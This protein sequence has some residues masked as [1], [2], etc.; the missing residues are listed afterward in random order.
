MHFGIFKKYS[1]LFSTISFLADALIVMVSGYL[2]YYFRF[3]TFIEIPALYHGAIVV[4]VIIAYLCFYQFDLY[5]PL[6]G[7]QIDMLFKRLF[8]AWAF[9]LFVF[10]VL[11]LFTKT[12]ES[13]SRIWLAEWF[14]IGFL[15]SVIF[16]ILA[17]LVMRS[18]RKKGYNH[19][20][21]YIIGAG[22]LG[23]HIAKTIH[24]AMWA[25]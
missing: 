7:K 16:R 25:G 13:F 5:E 19:R 12:G 22:S 10:A 20:T 24:E 14:L 8:T 21:L 2:T 18:L 6:R 17:L 11:A 4:G 15:S 23:K 9:I 1:S 3:G